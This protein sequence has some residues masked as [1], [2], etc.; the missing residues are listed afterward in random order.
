MCLLGLVWWTESSRV[1]EMLLSGSDFCVGEGIR[2]F[3][4]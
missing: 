1:V 4:F 3:K 2:Y